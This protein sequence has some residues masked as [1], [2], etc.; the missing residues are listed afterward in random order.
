MTDEF[1]ELQDESAREDQSLNLPLE[2]YPV[3]SDTQPVDLTKPADDERKRQKD[4]TTWGLIRT[5]LI[6]AVLVATLLSIWMPGGLVT[7]SLSERMQAAMQP[8]ISATATV[9]STQEEVD[10]FP[11]NRI[12]IVVGHLGNDSGAVC[13]NGI[14]EVDVN[15]D[16]ASLVQQRLIALGYEVDLLE[17]FD[18]RLQGYKGTI[19]IS[20]H[21]DSCEY[22]NDYATG[23]KVAA[24][25]SS[26]KGDNATRLVSCLADRYAAV[27]GMVYHYQSITDDMTR[28]HA[29]DEINPRTTAAIIETGFLNLD[30]AILTQNPEKVADGI[31]A[32]LL[33]FL[34][35]ETVSPTATP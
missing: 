25:L 22:I 12:G 29:F 35:N 7:Q 30:M 11:T 2:N 24:A 21:A 27:T 1:D 18:A 17:E 34:N 10:D 33:C 19:L 13:S 32:G 8:P 9:I 16:V 5:V 28:Y 26:K 6:A 14:R 20:I 3:S 15:A 31:V 23:F 4:L